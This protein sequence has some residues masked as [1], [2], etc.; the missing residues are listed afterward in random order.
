M[1]DRVFLGV[2]VYEGERTMVVRLVPVYHSAVSRECVCVF[3]C[4]HWKLALASNLMKPKS[5][6]T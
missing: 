1:V 5:T 3:V 4:V 2:L 6:R